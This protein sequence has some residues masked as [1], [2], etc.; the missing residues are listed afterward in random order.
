MNAHMSF[1]EWWRTGGSQEWSDAL[2]AEGGT[3]AALE[4]VFRKGYQAASQPATT[5]EGQGD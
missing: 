5:Q 4:M 1:Q 3:L 2:D